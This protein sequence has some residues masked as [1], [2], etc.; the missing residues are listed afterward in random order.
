MSTD[1]FGRYL[2][3]E[4]LP[5][6]YQ[7]NGTTTKK[8][9][10]KNMHSLARLD[11]R[12]YVKTIAGLKRTGDMV[13]TTEGM[14][15]GLDDIAPE[16]NRRNTALQPYVQQFKSATTSAKRS[17]IA[18]AA[19]EKMI[20]IALKHKGTMTQQVESGARG[21][22]FSYSNIVATPA[23]AR[24][25]GGKTIPWL[26]ERSY[27]EGL[28]PSDYWAAG[29][30]AILNTIK[31]SVSVAE[32]GEL[33]KILIS[34][35]SDLIVTEEDCGTHNGIT[36]S[37]DSPDVVDRFLARDAS[38]FSRNALVT[39]QTQS[40]IM[41][42]G[43]SKVVVRSPMTCEASDGVCKKCQG[44][45]EK[46][47]VHEYGTN[48]GVRA[49]QALAEPMTQM[50][51]STKHGSKSSK[52]ERHQVGGLQGIR[53]TI[54]S[55]KQFINK[56]T[57]AEQDGLV[58]RIE[59]APQ[60]GNF[61]WLGKKDHYV[62]PN[63]DVTVHVGQQVERGD[64]L[65][66]GIPKPDEVVKYKGISAG[67]LYVVN[68]L[69]KL[70]KDQGMNHDKRHF[71]LLAKGE[72]N[73]A[74]ILDN[75]NNSKFLKGDIVS[76]NILK[77]EL[78]R[79]AKELPLTEANGK[80]LGKEYFQFSAGSRVTPATIRTLKS[81]GIKNVYVAPRAPEVE[82]VMKPATR[83]PMLNPDWM[84]R[85]S[86]RN[87]KTMIQQAAHGGEESNLHGTNPVPAY[88][89]GTD[90]GRGEKGRY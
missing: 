86:H 15:I 19:Q 83:A 66:E 53:Q 78:A 7:I 52:K 38:K 69:H 2:L 9:L 50:A 48:V 1:T 62:T 45:D 90:F 55:P 24:D 30:E 49:A 85:L 42:D 79:G 10:N 27:S 44:L 87:L 73:H 21:K 47:H 72:L 63:L 28:K 6:K 82:F 41:K 74:R 71:E 75:N 46:G 18:E 33:S 11:P 13:S 67:R 40:Q 37:A 29:N 17:Q 26:I 80:T 61:V 43:L 8:E 39:P 68:H 76:Y 22:P 70:Y 20:G 14:S 60:G 58:T 31:S 16:Y 88:V 34:N 81:E 23:A 89:I 36:L 57:L 64:A 12:A 32:P 54:E 56:A 59:K 65:S 84:A 4:Y 3:N 5:T 51:L 35:M 77:S 25:A